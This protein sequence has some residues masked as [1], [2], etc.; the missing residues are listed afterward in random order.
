MR[1]LRY[2]GEDWWPLLTDDGFDPARGWVKTLHPDML[3]NRCGIVVA[4]R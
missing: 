4:I 3:V 2:A 1:P